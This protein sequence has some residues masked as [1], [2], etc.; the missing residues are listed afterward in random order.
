MFLL[1]R[2]AE[3]CKHFLFPKWNADLEHAQKEPS[4]CAALGDA[5]PV[6]G[7]WDVA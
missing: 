4:L 7:L 3:S 6:Q 5:K 2:T 1:K